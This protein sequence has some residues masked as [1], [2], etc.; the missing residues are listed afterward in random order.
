[1]HTGIPQIVSIEGSATNTSVTLQWE[2]PD[3]IQLSDTY[4]NVRCTLC[5]YVHVDFITNINREYFQFSSFSTY[6]RALVVV[7]LVI[8]TDTGI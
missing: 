8:T 3:N 4:F 7:E 1:M 2:L 5:Y 6:G